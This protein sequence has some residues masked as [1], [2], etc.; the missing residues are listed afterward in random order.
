MMVSTVSGFGNA[1]LRPGLSS[2]IT[3]V[4]GREEQGVVIG[5]SQ[6]LGSVA[7]IVAPA[8]GGFLIGRGLL[9]VW[10]SVASF[11][12]AIGLLLA[13]S[14]SS[15]VPRRVPNPEHGS[16]LMLPLATKRLSDAPSCLLLPG[17]VARFGRSGEQN[18][19][20]VSSKVEAPLRSRQLRRARSRH[21]DPAT[22]HRPHDARRRRADPPREA[23]RRG[24]SRAISGT[25]A[26]EASRA[27]PPRPRAAE[28]AA[29]DAP[30]TKGEREATRRQE[31]RLS[32]EA[33]AERVAITI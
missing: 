16:P 19:N 22:Q 32:K 15:K 25:Y 12:A 17:S 20:K 8:L 33:G 1:V 26:R 23:R 3:Q 27:R 9:S 18:V 29:A 24:T 28:E 5:M 21:Q 10:T 6:S 31:S 2:L 13:R 4:A 14:G 7:Q 11:A 30:I